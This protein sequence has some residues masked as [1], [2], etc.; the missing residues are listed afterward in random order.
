MSTSVAIASGA[1]A[2]AAASAARA[3]AEHR[4]ACRLMMPSYKEGPETTV[5]QRQAYSECVQLVYP[6][7]I[8]GGETMLI[9]IL[10]ASAFIGIACGI[11]YQKRDGYGGLSDYVMFGILGGITGPVL[12]GIV[13]ALIAGGV[14]LFS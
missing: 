1:A 7:E 5:E 13:F 6:Q 11:W 8:S 4:E 3:R 14:F 10:I 9:K 2:S 12:V